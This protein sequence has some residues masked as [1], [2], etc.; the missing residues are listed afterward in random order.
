MEITL[1]VKED[2]VGITL[3]NKGVIIDETD[4]TIS[5]GLDNMLIKALDNLIARNKIERLSIKNVEIG[6]ELRGEAISSMVIKTVK[7]ALNL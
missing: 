4:L 5:Q 3:K 2:F 1:Q 7:T 6:G